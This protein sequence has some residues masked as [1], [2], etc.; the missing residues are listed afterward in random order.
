MTTTGVMHSGDVTHDTRERA[1][2]DFLARD[3]EWWTTHALSVRGFNSPPTYASS[4]I[5][6]QARLGSLPGGW[7]IEKRRM[8][9]GKQ[10]EYRAVSAGRGTMFLGRRTDT[11]SA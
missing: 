1:F 8:P 3:G 7:L 11:K 10:F 2:L 4:L 9:G 5:H 6:Q